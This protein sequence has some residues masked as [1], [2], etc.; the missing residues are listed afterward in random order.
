MNLAIGSK[1]TRRTIICPVVDVNRGI[2][3]IN[4]FEVDL[5]FGVKASTSGSIKGDVCC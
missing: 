4:Q 5:P 1:V 2:L 3:I